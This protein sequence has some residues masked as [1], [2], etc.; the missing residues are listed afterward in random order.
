MAR[1]TFQE[2]NSKLKAALAQLL[3]ATLIA[4]CGGGGGGGGSTPAPPPVPEP[5]V[6]SW[7]GNGG[8][9]TATSGAYT[10]TGS[11]TVTGAAMNFSATGQSATI[12]VN[13]S[14][15]SGAFTYTNS[16]CVVGTNV[17]IAQND[18]TFTVTDLGAAFACTLIFS[19]APGAGSVAFPVTGPVSLGGGV[20]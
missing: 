8:G 16:G 4:G 6:A 5:F 15:Y 20:Q 1:R 7:T 18:S 10:A 3:A 9:F 11:N 17:S 12:A 13:Q 2:H 14:A 19:G